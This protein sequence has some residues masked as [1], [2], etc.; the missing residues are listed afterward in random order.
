MGDTALQ[1]L[2][3]A[4]NNEAD[5]CKTL[6]PVQLDREALNQVITHTSPMNVQLD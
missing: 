3:K 1:A 4:F 6:R 5:L 2:D